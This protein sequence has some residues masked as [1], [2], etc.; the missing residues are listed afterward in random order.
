M[1][2]DPFRKWDGVDTVCALLVD[3]GNKQVKISQDSKLVHRIN[4]MQA[5]SILYA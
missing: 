2:K 1:V 5:R 4:N 3:L